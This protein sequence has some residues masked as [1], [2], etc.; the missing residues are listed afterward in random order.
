MGG[1]PEPDW[2]LDHVLV[3]ATPGTSRLA[4]PGPAE[5]WQAWWESR[6]GPTPDLTEVL[7][8]QG[9]VATSRQLEG[10]AISARRRRTRLSRGEWFRA[11]TGCIVPLDL[12]DADR[13]E[14]A[15][16]QHTVRAAAV[17]LLR[18]D[19][20]VS[21]RSAAVVRGLPVFA[22]PAHPE[23]TDDLQ[24]GLGRRGHSHVYGAGIELDDV[25]EW[26]GIPV[27]SVART[28]VDLGRHDRRDAIM[29]VDAALRERLVTR[30]DI[31]RSLEQAVGW[32]GVKQAREVLALADPRAESPLESLARL[33]LHDDGFPPP[34]DL[35]RWFGH[36]RVD[37]VFDRQR[38][39]LEIDGLGKYRNTTPAEEKR[40]ERRLRRYGYRVERLTWDELVVN[41]PATRR[42]LRPLFGL[43]V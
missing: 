26:F 11:A 9:F 15:R 30:D 21:G 35:Q 10:F 17:V 13:F 16:R 29:A 34:D 2:Y 37:M 41:W 12:R 32:P 25:G 33:V 8:R 39:I 23:V 42:W 19:H 6:T 7:R 3:K 22:L 40:R 18:S 14:T 20:A 5:L 24:N 28:L 43:P 4:E 31:D 36:D 1:L 38:L 27:L